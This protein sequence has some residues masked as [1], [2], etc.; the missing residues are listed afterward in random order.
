MGMQVGV[1][2][3]RVTVG[4]RRREDPLRLYLL[5]SRPTPTGIG[6]IAFNPRDA[7]W[8]KSLEVV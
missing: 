4:E 3:P 7:L 2:S 5:Y 1:T 6:G 8:V